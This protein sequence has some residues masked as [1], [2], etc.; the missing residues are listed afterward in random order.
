M[1]L[2]RVFGGS[3]GLFGWFFVKNAL[4]SLR[5]GCPGSGGFF[6]HLGGWCHRSWEKWQW[7]SAHVVWCEVCSP[8]KKSLSKFSVVVFDKI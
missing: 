8:A 4:Q 5:I 1:Y 6:W 3:F 7:G 2:G